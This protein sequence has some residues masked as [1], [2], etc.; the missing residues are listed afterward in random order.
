MHCTYSGEFRRLRAHGG[1]RGRIWLC[2]VHFRGFGWR[3]APGTER[4]V[5]TAELQ[6][7]DTGQNLKECSDDT[8]TTV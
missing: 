5:K 4:L 3:R 8:K 1:E 2:A 6:Q 7:L